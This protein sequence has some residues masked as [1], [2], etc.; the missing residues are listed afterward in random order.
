[1]DNIKENVTKILKYNDFVKMQEAVVNG[2]LLNIATEENQD[3][4]F[5]RLV[6]PKEPEPET[7]SETANQHI[8]KELSTV[9]DDGSNS[10]SQKVIVANT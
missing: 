8:K 5:N 4:I 10:I 9:K 6:T 1:M 3:D 2:R 7:N